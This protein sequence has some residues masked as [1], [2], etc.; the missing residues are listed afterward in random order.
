MESCGTSL[1]RS[2]EFRET[3]YLRKVPT[4]KKLRILIADDHEV[5]RH[6]LCVVLQT[7]REWEVCGQAFD[8]RD[9]VAK[10]RELSPDLVI[11][12]FHMPRLSGHAER[13]RY[14]S[15]FGAKRT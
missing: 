2:L 7:C 6:G 1:K 15:G 3:H 11:L 14:L 8:G 4:P 10:A 13:I 9:A 12:D 5:V